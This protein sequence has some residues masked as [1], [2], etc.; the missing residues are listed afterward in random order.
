M[1]VLGFL[2]GRYKSLRDQYL[3]L[4]S[5]TVL[6]G[7]NGAGKTNVIEAA[8][9]ILQELRR[10]DA[11]ISSL[12]T[13][14]RETPRSSDSDVDED[15]GVLIDLDLAHR[16]GQPERA[17]L[18]LFLNGPES[19]M[20]NPL[21]GDRR[22]TYSEMDLPENVPGS[23]EISQRYWA[24]VLIGE[25]L[26]GDPADRELLALSLAS[27]TTFLIKGPVSLVVDPRRIDD[28]ALD[29]ARRLGQFDA[30]DVLVRCAVQLTAS[31]E[32]EWIVVGE[33]AGESAVLHLIYHFMLPEPI[34]LETEPAS[35]DEEMTAR[36]KLAADYYRRQAG[37]QIGHLRFKGDG[38]PAGQGGIRVTADS[39]ESVFPPLHLTGDGWGLQ[40]DEGNVTIAPGVTEAAQDLLRRAEQLAP[41]FITRLG[42]L[43]LELRTPGLALGEEP[44]RILMRE[45]GGFDFEAGAG[46]AGV[47]R[48]IAAVLREAGRQ[49][50]S[51]QRPD[52]GINVPWW[53]P[54][55][56][57]D[58][59][60][61]F[62]GD[63][64][65]DPWVRLESWVRRQ[66]GDLPPRD[67]LYFVDEPESHLH[68]LAVNSVRDWLVAFG[69]RAAGVIVATH[70]P[71]F[72][73]ASSA[74]A[75]L[76]HVARGSNGTT[77]TPIK[78]AMYSTL[79]TRAAGMGLT[80]GHLLQMTRLILIVEG[81]ADK[82]VV[83]H[84]YGAELAEARIRIIPLQGMHEALSLAES[85]VFMILDIPIAL[86]FDSVRGNI[87]EAV[88]QA[89]KTGTRLSREE[90]MIVKLIQ[91]FEGQGKP[92]PKPISNPLPDIVCA[93]PDEGV[94]RFLQRTYQVGF[95]GWSP[96]LDGYVSKRGEPFKDWLV[97]TLGVPSPRGG[98]TAFVSQM[99]R[100][101]LADTPP[102]LGPHPLLQRT[103]RTVLRLAAKSRM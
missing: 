79:V 12:G 24:D 30:A 43:V 29:A 2:I 58:D 20:D 8:M 83:E 25:G 60:P 59:E 64:R 81:A 55:W 76:V 9:G 86:L 84:F 73:D 99:I 39:A 90:E 89:R 27:Q 23:V 36:I 96:L 65:G 69:K 67:I 48:W 102:E 61:G 17:M 32:P 19:G 82:R 88:R 42:R 63:P 66:L 40:D 91:S 22:A 31:T 56:T 4:A 28:S 47:N 54:D 52:A 11:D 95:P 18:H 33:V 7:E 35:I 97:K 92:V 77:L 98:G 72:L 10:H 38:T 6:F 93:L 53:D 34:V 75:G 94:E 44:L 14:D 1:R 16:E 49:Q 46:G 70:A 13:W 51:E 15:V 100:E 101:V 74:D 5:L 85:E 26:P 78:G 103:I 57:T 50:Q 45:T 71:E 87:I 80:P 41:E 21:T 62:M 37:I 3:P 68:P